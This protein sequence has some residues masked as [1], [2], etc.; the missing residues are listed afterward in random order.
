[1]IRGILQRLF[2]QS[3]RTANSG[4]SNRVDSE[5][6]RSGTSEFPDS[7]STVRDEIQSGYRVRIDLASQVLRLKILPDFG[8]IHGDEVHPSLVSFT[9]TTFFSKRK[10][11]FIS[12]SVLSQKAKQFDDG[13]VAAMAL[14]IQRG[15][16][17]LGSKPDFLKELSRELS[18]QTPQ[19]A[20]PVLPL[21]L[22]AGELGGGLG[23]VPKAWRAEVDAILKN[24]L[25]D[26]I[27]SKPLGIYT[28]TT[29][30]EGIFRQDRMLQTG[31]KAEGVSALTSIL[32]ERADL[33]GSYEKL[34][35]LGE[36]LTNRFSTPDLRK[37]A[38]AE[39]AVDEDAA[40]A[41][42][43]PSA[44]PE[45][46]LLQRMFPPPTAV[47]EGFSL[48]D[49][50]I[51]RI[52]NGDLSLQPT[53]DSGW[54]EHQLWSLEPLV[55]PEQTPEAEHLRFDTTY[56]DHLIKLFKGLFALTRETHVKT[57]DVVFC[58]AALP[59]DPP[60]YIAPS[61]TIEPL[62]TSYRRRA[63]AYRFVHESL[64]ELI[65][66]DCLLQMNRVTEKGPVSKNLA[67]ELNQMEA[68]FWGAYLVSMQ[69]LGLSSIFEPV[70]TR[71]PKLDEDF[72]LKHFRSWKNHV[73]DD[74]DVAQDSRMMVPI[75]YDLG[76]KQVKV[77][78]FLGWSEAWIEASFAK[79]PTIDVRDETGKK[80]RRRIE[81]GRNLF[82]A[83]QPVMAELYVS[84]L[85]DRP[86][87]RDH[88]DRHKT[89]AAILKNLV[90]SENG[91]VHRLS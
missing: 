47:P 29:E 62:A 81:F 33:R 35:S 71:Y 46:D 56:K 79:E 68:L 61:L 59:A 23:P 83:A 51:R 26:P 41:L 88:C 18:R 36:R 70:S 11:E 48:M 20:E 78:V 80:H 15:L 12:A 17:G 38:N 31:I 73:L 2:G 43:P 58:G 9:E 4:S 65:G 76:R 22:A 7:S 30:M 54:Y 8:A 21:I 91:G 67:D 32:Q 66:N 13:F 90:P 6:R 5:E 25:E 72:C 52:T 44:A 40:P 57:L 42:F 3:A 74:D 14:A 63:L 53:A 87:F 64:L 27:R 50:V 60:L 37:W 77:W 82:R 10:I 55:I 24:F 28:W 19:A 45:T 49:E 39:S 85:M 69:E 16:L 86:K 34:L 1:M 84:E 89:V 75:F